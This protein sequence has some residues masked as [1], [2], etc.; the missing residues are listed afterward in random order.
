MKFV[1]KSSKTVEDAL[2]EALVEL[3]ATKDEVEVEILEEPSKG[4]FGII[5]G[6]E[7]KI[8]VTKKDDPKKIAQTFM[9]NLLNKMDIE[10][11]CNVTLE[12]EVIQV[13]IVNLS[14]DDIGVLIGKRGSGLDS[15]QYLLNLVVNKNGENLYK[16]LVDVNNYRKKREEALVN[17]ANKMA[18]RVLTYRKP[19]K[20][21]P[22][23]PYERRIIHSTL[24]NFD[25][26]T[27]YS[28]GNEPYRRV[29]I[30]LKK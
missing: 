9:E 11:D 19:V 14:D 28:E 18:K 15:I 7:A 27:T 3:N 5:G 12:G 2:N 13:E 20:L 22:M 17:L 16:T 1:I 23:N 8:K 24:Q 6:K 4:L 26:I 25:G 30:T 21:E 10:A 29:V